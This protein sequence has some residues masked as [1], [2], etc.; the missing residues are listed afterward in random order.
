MHKQDA[1]AHR[2]IMHTPAGQP[3]PP[4][5]GRVSREQ[6]ASGA[7]PLT[8]AGKS[9]SHSGRRIIDSVRSVCASIDRSVAFLRADPKP[10]VDARTL[11]R[12]PA[13]EPR[14]RWSSGG[15][16]PAGAPAPT[17][18]PR[19]AP[20]R[21]GTCGRHPP[22]PETKSSVPR[23]RASP[24][25][26]QRACDAHIKRPGAPSEIRP[27]RAW[28][29]RAAAGVGWALAQRV[30]PPEH[31]QPGGPPQQR[32]C[33]DGC[34]VWPVDRH[35]QLPVYL[36][37]APSTPSILPR[38][39][40]RSVVAVAGLVGLG[41]SALASQP[42]TARRVAIRPSAACS[43]MHASAGV[44]WHEPLAAATPLPAVAPPP[45]STSAPARIGRSEH[46]PHHSAMCCDHHVHQTNHLQVGRYRP[47]RM[48]SQRM[49]LFGRPACASR[50]AIQS[51]N[52]LASTA[53]GAPPPPPRS[54]A[55]RDGRR[56][57]S[58]RGV[59]WGAGAA[60]GACA[61]QRRGPRARQR[62][63]GCHTPPRARSR[64]DSRPT[65]LAHSPSGPRSP[66]P[67]PNPPPRARAGRAAGA[68]RLARR[69]DARRGARHAGS[70]ASGG[71]A[72]CCDCCCAARTAHR[73]GRAEAHS[74]RV[75]GARGRCRGQTSRGD[76]GHGR[77]VTGA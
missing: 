65:A 40:G 29:A 62:C 25:L 33:T 9:L 39:V 6:R 3:A 22:R 42:A 2:V 51:E 77:G 1:H 4:R 10:R 26:T 56:P 32:F 24:P 47:D 44:P 55:G 8:R 59:G 15:R 67:T 27:P 45:Q 69:S 75:P 17:L 58:L 41:G 46:Q 76:H 49:H 74:A 53:R 16:A 70:H 68:E 63:A 21:S 20:A 31:A 66:V 50:S 64:E 43:C 12:A 11:R 73:A 19:P 5:T 30:P 35:Q 57:R 71:A 7:Q 38:S 60:R 36:N 48:A 34:R 54:R 13:R 28:P 23:A 72:R 14:I 18:A 52:L 61:A 37:L